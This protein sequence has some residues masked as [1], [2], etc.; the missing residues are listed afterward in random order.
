MTNKTTDKVNLIHK[1]VITWNKVKKNN[2]NQTYRN[3]V[4]ERIHKMEV[5]QDDD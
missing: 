3:K 2:T 1:R 4:W 5:K